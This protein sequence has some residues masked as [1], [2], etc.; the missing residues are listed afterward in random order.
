MCYDPAVEK[1]RYIKNPFLKQETVQRLDAYEAKLH[2]LALLAT[3]EG[4][5]TPNIQTTLGAFEYEFKGSNCF[6]DWDITYSKDTDD[7]RKLLMKRKDKGTDAVA[8]QISI[9]YTAADKHDEAAYFIVHAAPHRY[10]NGAVSYEY[11]YNTNEC[12]ITA[13]K[14]VRDFVQDDN[15]PLSGAIKA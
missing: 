11:N 4:F 5:L 7:S 2:T 15:E 1:I 13:R 14:F 12:L 3:F 9:N 8:E 10:I 6:W